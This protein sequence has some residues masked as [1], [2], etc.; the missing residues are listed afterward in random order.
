[1]DC[2][3]M[4]ES[5]RTKLTSSFALWVAVDECTQLVWDE[6]NNNKSQSCK[7]KITSTNT[8]FYLSSGLANQKASLSSRARTKTR[9]T[10]F[11]G[12]L[13]SVLSN[14][15]AL[16]S[17]PPPPLHPA[18]PP[19]PVSMVTRAPGLR[20]P[21]LCPLHHYL[22]FRPPLTGALTQAQASTQTAAQTAT[23]LTQMRGKMAQHKYCSPASPQVLITK[24][25]TAKTFQLVRWYG[26]ETK[27]KTKKTCTP[28][29]LT[30]A[31]R[32]CPRST[33]D[34]RSG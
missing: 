6:K 10:S 13:P 12:A 19:T 17:S 3:I 9:W 14:S 18:P 32:E 27:K 20:W 28:L 26:L 25:P 5:S 21:Q 23:A 29:I 11:P 2:E 15:S 34:K 16:P 7:C 8:D 24:P 22:H 4:L 30:L 33:S 1:M 31:S